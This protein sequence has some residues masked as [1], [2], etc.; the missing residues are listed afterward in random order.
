MAQK[1]IV[2]NPNGGSAGNA[3][4]K[5]RK[6]KRDL[7]QFVN[8]Y[9]ANPSATWTSRNNNQKDQ[10]LLD[11]VLALQAQVSNLEKRVEALEAAR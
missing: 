6:A 1:L 9:E 11:L 4:K 5:A 3:R 10:Q 2:A 8:D 7:R